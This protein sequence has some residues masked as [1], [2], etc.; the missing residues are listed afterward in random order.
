MHA[1]NEMV[2]LLENRWILQIRKIN[3][4]LCQL[5]A[6][7]SA[8]GSWNASMSI[9]TITL[10][11]IYKPAPKTRFHICPLVDLSNSILKVASVPL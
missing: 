7:P 9:L 3:H 2:K 10:S 6:Q 11:A 8:P 4:T 1:R 5:K